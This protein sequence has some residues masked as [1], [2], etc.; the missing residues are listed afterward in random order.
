MKKYLLLLATLVILSSFRCNT[1]IWSFPI[2][3]QPLNESKEIIENL[4]IEISPKLK[5]NDSDV[6]FENHYYNDDSGT[7]FDG[8]IAYL[9]MCSLNDAD[10]NTRYLDWQPI[11]NILDNYVIKITD[12]NGIY[13]DYTTPTLREMIEKSEYKDRTLSLKDENGNP[14][15]PEMVF[16]VNLEKK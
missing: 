14:R 4:S 6:V 2:V 1:G 8:Y 10:L 13:K 12:P 5:R 7:S 11:Q 15:T 3:I 16:T 9:Y